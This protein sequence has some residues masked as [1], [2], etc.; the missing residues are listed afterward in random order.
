[1]VIAWLFSA[2]DKKVN[3]KSAKRSLKLRSMLRGGGR[4]D[5]MTISYI[6]FAL[7]KRIRRGSVLAFG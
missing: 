7:A 1:M 6:P 5:V 4:R 2:S 3:F